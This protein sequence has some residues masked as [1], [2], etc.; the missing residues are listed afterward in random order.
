MMRRWLIDAADRLEAAAELARDLRATGGLGV[1]GIRVRTEFLAERLWETAQ[2]VGVLQSLGPDP[3]AQLALRL[4]DLYRV[5]RRAHHLALAEGFG[6]LGVDLET[7]AS[8]LYAL[9]AELA[10]LDAAA[11]ETRPQVMSGACR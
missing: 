2:R 4:C 5:A 10:S 11:G 7:I 3:R 6:K 1:E 8:E 9:V